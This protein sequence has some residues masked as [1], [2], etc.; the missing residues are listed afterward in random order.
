[1]TPI[2]RSKTSL[3][4]GIAVFFGLLV[5]CSTPRPSQQ[6]SDTAVVISGRTP[7]EISTV[8][9]E[10]FKRHQFEIASSKDEALVFEK[11]G[12]FMNDMMSPSWVDGPTWL[13]VKVFQTQVDSEQTRLG[14]EVF[15][16]QQPKDPMFQREQPYGGHKQEVKRLMQEIAQNLNH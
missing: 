14:C 7:E 8:I 11:R 9:K 15:L 4:Y 5:G 12:S 13:R 10:T 16:V 6:L 1:M 2:H 3:R